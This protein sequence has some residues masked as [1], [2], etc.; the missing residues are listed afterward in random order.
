MKAIVL[1]LFA[2]WIMPL[3][4]LVTLARAVVVAALACLM[5]PS[6]A[7]ACSC[8]QMSAE[9][10]VRSTPVI[11]QGR[12]VEVRRT[13]PEG[14][15]YEEVAATM[16]V[17][18]RWKGDVGEVIRVHGHTATPICGY[19]DF[20]EGEV[21]LVMAHPRPE[22]DGVTTDLCSM[23]PPSGDQRAE[24]DRILRRIG[25]NRR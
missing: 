8:I 19:S 18:E 17:S 6:A 25:V 15:G 11:F 3:T 5:V 14:A 23:P 7:L 4:H 12:V 13:R 1:T 10:R 2:G 9:Q 16:Q 20:L 22:G 24:I 21:L